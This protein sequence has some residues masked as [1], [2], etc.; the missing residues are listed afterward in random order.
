MT[1][2]RKST[3]KK[4]GKSRPVVPAA[5]SRR[6]I[7][8]TITLAELIAGA[9]GSQEASIS[10][11]WAIFSARLEL[12]GGKSVQDFDV[13]LDGPELVITLTDWHPDDLIS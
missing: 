7:E 1:K 10:A 8:N 9:L 3:R 11:P 13:N 2:T 6:R 4:A 12:S 5:G